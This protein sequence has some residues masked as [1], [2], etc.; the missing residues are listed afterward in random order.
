MKNQSTIIK[1]ILL[2]VGA[3]I[4]I[5]F[6]LVAPNRYY[7]HIVNMAGLWILLSL[8]LNICMGYCGQINLGLGAFWAV[9]AYTAAILNTRLGVPIWINLPLGMILAGI[10][11]A[12]VALPMLKVKSHYLALVTIGLAETINVILVNETWLTEG[13]LGI[14]FIKM[15]ELFG[16]PI[17]GAERYYYLVLIAVIL[18]YLVGRRIVSHRVGRSFVA[19]RDDET[20]AKAMG[21]NVPYYQ[22]LS[23]AIAGVYCGLAGVLYAHMTTYI[24]PDIFEF[25]NALFVLTATLMGGMGSLA[26]SLIGALAMPLIQEYLR[27]FKNWQLVFFGLVIMLTV[28]FMPGGVVGLARKIEEAGGIRLP[29]ARKQT[30]EKP[31]GEPNV[32]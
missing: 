6:P 25:K 13:P 8:G 3:L 12:L 26:G 14:S 1:G 7:V 24:S 5:S 19:I 31:K 18:G 30:E 22:V 2:V 27:A 28:L 9:G 17:D 29:W 23:N 11:A 20:A 4:L 16:I 10:T 32:S 21:V 15:P